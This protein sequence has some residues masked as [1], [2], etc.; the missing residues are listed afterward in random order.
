MDKKD[1]VQKLLESR[2]LVSP[3]I[4]DKITDKNINDYIQNTKTLIVDPP[5]NQSQIN[6]VF[7]K[8]K[9][10]NKLTIQDF[11]KYYN[12]MYEHLR[13]ILLK[14]TEAT[15]INKV[16]GI[17]SEVTVIGMVKEPDSGGFILEDTTG[18]ITVI[19]NT[20]PKINSVIAVTGV[21]RENKLFKKDITYPDIPLPK[22]IPTIGA[23]ILFTTNREIERDGYNIIFTSTKEEAPGIY[24]IESNPSWAE[25]DMGSQKITV[26]IYKTEEAIMETDVVNHLKTRMLPMKTTTPNTNIL[27]DTV[28]DLI[29]LIQEPEW[30]KNYKGITLISTSTSAS[31]DMKTREVKLL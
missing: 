20:M 17:S 9:I 16:G 28:P 30:M 10:K 24:N 18:H 29:W 27:I 19:S 1:V 3:K 15:S 22:T 11:V 25:V 14:K 4:I 8:K 5:I 13:K 7:R 6:V 12:N 26:L 31:V 23:N 21:V 2:L